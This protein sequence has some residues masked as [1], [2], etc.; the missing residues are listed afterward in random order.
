[1]SVLG[2][3][4][5]EGIVVP[6]WKPFH[7]LL[8]EKGFDLVSIQSG[9]SDFHFDLECAGPQVFDFSRHLRP[10]KRVL[11]RVEPKCVNPFQYLTKVN[12]FYAHHLVISNQF[13]T[14]DESI[15][16]ENGH[17]PSKNLL[18]QI[19]ESTNNSRDRSG[20]CLLNQNKFSTVPG[21]LYSLRRSAINR[22][23]KNNIDFVLGGRDWEK[24]NFWE[25]KSKVRNL[26][27][28]FG[29]SKGISFSNFFVNLNKK[30]SNLIMVGE[31]D[32]TY[33]FLSKYEYCL[34]IENEETYVSEKLLNAIISGCIP[35]YVGP[36]LSDFGFPRNIA[37]EVGRNP[38]LMIDVFFN[39]SAIKKEEIRKVGRIWIESELS[40]ERWGVE[41]G[42]EKLTDILLRVCNK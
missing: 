27:V 20:I 1:M 37:V 19:L 10:D 16:W 21:E 42:F 29:R 12:V 7:N 39:L 24:S 8:L 13:K 30:S 34:V 36:D 28:N 35:I 23:L 4:I 9:S 5:V 31:I 40:Y 18:N 17:L 33:E 26:F 2:E 32:D 3:C 6:K 22:F 38:K 14:K 25:F 41:P 15:F 11:I